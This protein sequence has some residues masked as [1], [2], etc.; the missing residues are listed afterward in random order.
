MR[1]CRGLDCTEIR[2]PAIIT[3]GVFDGLHLGHQLIMKTVVERAEK[4]GFAATVL[5]FSPHPRAVLYPETAPPLLHTF[6]HKMEGMSI[7]GIEQAVVLEF[8]LELAAMRA[9]AFTREILCEKLQA[10]EVHLGKGFAFGKGRE[11][12]ID[13]LREFS[14]RYGFVAEEVPEVLLRGR[15]ISST[16]V[17]KAIKSGRMSLARRMLG[18]SYGVAGRV[19]GGRRMGRELGFPTANFIPENSV[20]PADGVYVTIALIDGKWRR[21]I[22]N[23]GVRPTVSGTGERL[24]ECHLFD[25][26][27]DLYD[28]EI[29]LRFL[30]RLR[31]EKRFAS[32]AELKARIAY[33]CDRAR[34][35]FERALV[36]K[37]LEFE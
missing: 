31:E 2:H 24:V 29:R 21:G 20:L 5:T 25:F 27:E 13:K 10:R 7:I 36:R 1:I 4:T 9:E 15:R 8:N 37:H 34:E 26:D 3:M 11:G 19:V 33:D 14:S 35:Y 28:K 22:S 23:V 32:L 17:R 30:H 6:E 12:N 16:S 18:R